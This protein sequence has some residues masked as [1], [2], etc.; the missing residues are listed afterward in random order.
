MLVYQSEL[1]RIRR[2]ASAALASASQPDGGE[3]RNSQQVPA[4]AT[5]L[6]G[7]EGDKDPALSE[8]LIKLRAFVDKLSSLSTLGKPAARELDRLIAEACELREK[9]S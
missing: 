1:K 2:I 5:S 3:D 8:E 6:P 7:T 9:Q 4:V